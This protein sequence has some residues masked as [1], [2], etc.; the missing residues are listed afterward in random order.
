MKKSLLFV[1]FGTLTLTL[2]GCGNSDPGVSSSS[3]VP[4]SSSGSAS[5]SEI[6]SSGLIEY[7]AKKTSFYDGGLSAEDLASK[8]GLSLDATFT[9]GNVI[10]LLYAALDGQMPTMRGQRVL[11]AN[12]GYPEKVTITTPEVK[13][14]MT[15]L[16]DYGLWSDFTD[17]ADVMTTKDIDTIM[18]R[19]YQ[20]FGTNEKDDFCTA[21]NYDFYFNDS[22]DLTGNSDSFI[23]QKT[24]LID[25]DKA[26]ATAISYAKQFIA[27]G[28]SYSTRYKGALDYMEGES[29]YSFFE[30]EG[31]DE[32]IASI[33][34]PSTNES[35]YSAC[36]EETKN[37][38]ESPLLEFGSVDVT[39]NSD[40][41]SSP[42]VYVT[43]GRIDMTKLDFT[44][45]NLVERMETAIET[46]LKNLNYGDE[47]VKTKTALIMAFGKKEQENYTTTFKDFTNAAS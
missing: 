45:E 18:Q 25:A 30:E 28:S 43:S 29:T 22:A 4:S 42:I 6:I 14:A 1:A 5:S 9:K 10:R 31:I 7:I 8:S 38:G 35:W 46:S 20:Y 34:T 26:N 23:Y 37:Y 39:E 27:S 15:W 21:N 41:Y 19:F 24:K 16:A 47:E 44:T 3:D 36:A 12:T 13:E 2:A 11:I 32:E 40:G 17:E 33:T